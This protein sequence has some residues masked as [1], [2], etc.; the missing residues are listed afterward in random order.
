[1]IPLRDENPSR[2]F[3]W[4]TLLLIGAN[5]AVFLY[6][7]SLPPR[8]LEILMLRFGAVPAAVFSGSRVLPGRSPLPYV[9][10]VTSMFLHGSILHLAGNM[11]YLW[12][13]GDNV[14]DRMGPLRF[15]LFYLICGIAAA[16]IQ[17]AARPDSTAP[18][19]GASGA[20]AGVLG[21]YA[22][23]F[24]GA[25]VQTLVFLFIFVRMIELPALFVLGAWFLMQL[26]SVPSSQGTGVAFFAH[27]GGFLAGMILM[28]GFVRRR[29]S[30][31]RRPY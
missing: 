23:L 3:P 6:E 13:F 9:T 24:P 15:I 2:T 8:A 11:L 31:M 28:A 26:L 21:A 29:G 27:I 7:F 30:R 20:I 4:V 12:I 1:M 17:I 25:R 19:V 22:L 16:A 18:L 10:L 14:E 5:V